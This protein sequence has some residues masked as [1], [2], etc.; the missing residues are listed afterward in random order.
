MEKILP[1]LELVVWFD[2][3]EETW[4]TNI[5]GEP[6]PMFESSNPFEALAFAQGFREAVR[7]HT[8]VTITQEGK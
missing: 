5:A 8:N 4:N 2:E 1:T 3:N 6:C 7:T